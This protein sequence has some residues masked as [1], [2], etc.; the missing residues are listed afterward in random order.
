ML[1]TLKQWLGREDPMTRA[2]RAIDQGRSG[3]ETVLGLPHRLSTP[4]LQRHFGA[5]AVASDASFRKTG[6]QG[7]WTLPPP[8]PEFEVRV[9]G[10]DEGRLTLGTIQGQ[11]PYQGLVVLSEWTPDHPAAVWQVRLEEPVGDSA[12]ALHDFLLNGDSA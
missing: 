5:D 6:C 1:S 10:N 4:L 3:I 9:Y 8:A 7:H 11:G 12:Q 2:A